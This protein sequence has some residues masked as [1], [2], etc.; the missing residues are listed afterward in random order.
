MHFKVKTVE[1]GRNSIF[2]RKQTI[3][4]VPLT[5][6]DDKSDHAKTT[7]AFSD[8]ANKQARCNVCV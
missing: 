7:I 2:R 8:S 4:Q 1:N 6:L 5:F 3:N